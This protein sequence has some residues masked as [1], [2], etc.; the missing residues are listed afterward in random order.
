MT[1]DRADR[2]AALEAEQ[3][4]SLSSEEA[5]T[6][7]TA[8]VSAVERAQ[9]LELVRWFRRRYP[10]GAERLAYVRQAYRRWRRDA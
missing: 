2:R 8:P 6:Y 3:Q 10:T 5:T 1:V 4:R 9:T 7:L